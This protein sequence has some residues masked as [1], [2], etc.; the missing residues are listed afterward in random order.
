MPVIFHIGDIVT[1]MGINETITG[2]IL[3]LKNKDEAREMAE[4]HLFDLDRVNFIHTKYLF[5]NTAEGDM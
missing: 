3:S 5:N 1:Y 2:I 4:V